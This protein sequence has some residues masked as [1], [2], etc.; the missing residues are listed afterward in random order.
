[1]FLPRIEKEGRPDLNLHLINDKYCAHKHAIVRSFLTQQPR[2]HI[3]YTPSYASWIN[4]IQRWFGII[5][6][7]AMRQGSF[8]RVKEL[9]A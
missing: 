9:I 1:M 3:H 8:L 7:R 2:F 5:T 6:Q 4:Q